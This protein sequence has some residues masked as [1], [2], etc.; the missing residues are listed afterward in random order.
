MCIAGKHDPKDFSS[1]QMVTAVWSFE[2]H[3]SFYFQ[4]TSML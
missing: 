3:V 1:M 4:V 2:T